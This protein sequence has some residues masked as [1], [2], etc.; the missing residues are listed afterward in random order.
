M[1]IID[2]YHF[3]AIRAFTSCLSS[4]E[5]IT[6]CFEPWCILKVATVYFLHLWLLVSLMWAMSVVFSD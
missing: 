5:R 2:G 3:T 1:A 6:C 4:D